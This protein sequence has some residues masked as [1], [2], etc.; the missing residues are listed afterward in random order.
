MSNSVS[1]KTI[2]TPIRSYL[3][4]GV[5]SLIVIFIVAFGEAYVK[6]S[7]EY[8]FGL[9]T[10]VTSSVK[11]A[12]RKIQFWQHL[13]MKSEIEE[14][15]NSTFAVGEVVT[16]EL[17]KVKVL[18]MFAALWRS[19]LAVVDSKDHEGGKTQRHLITFAVAYKTKGIP[20]GIK[21]VK[22]QVLEA[23]SKT[24]RINRQEGDIFILQE[25]YTVEV[26]DQ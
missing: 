3:L 23:K 21:T 13:P 1:M 18:P 6:D 5:I 20:D 17:N 4:L 25:D 16:V 7:P 24:L 14:D 26:L 15:L 10:G 19:Y 11:R 12:D 9:P 8:S 22:L 2:Q